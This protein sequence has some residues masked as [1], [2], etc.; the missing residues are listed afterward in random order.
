DFFRR[1]RSTQWKFNLGVPLYYYGMGRKLFGASMKYPLLRLGHFPER[2]LRN[3]L[4]LD[5]SGE[6]APRFTVPDIVQVPDERGRPELPDETIISL[7]KL[8][9]P[10][11]F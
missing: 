8:G 6:R 10:G 4:Y 7:D 9:V 3:K 1:E 11:Q 5:F 2:L